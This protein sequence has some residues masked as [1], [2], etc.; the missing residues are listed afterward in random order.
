MFRKWKRQN[1]NNKPKRAVHKAKEQRKGEY[2]KEK[3]KPKSI[4]SFPYG[5]R[6]QKRKKRKKKIKREH[7]E[8]PARKKDKGYEATKRK[9]L[10]N[11]G[12]E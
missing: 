3:Q 11:E 10:K 1:K 2:E 9:R 8:Q 5:E 6:I 7:Q 12:K 4:E